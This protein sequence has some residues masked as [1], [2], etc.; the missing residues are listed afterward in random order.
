MRLLVA[1]RKVTGQLRCVS[2]VLIPF[3]EGKEIPTVDGLS[4]HEDIWGGG[5]GGVTTYR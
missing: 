3:L 1:Q 2:P 5:D 4:R